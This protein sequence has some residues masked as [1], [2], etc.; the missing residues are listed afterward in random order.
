MLLTKKIADF[1][2]KFWGKYQWNNYKEGLDSSRAKIVALLSKNTHVIIDVGCGIG[3]LEHILTSVSP[4]NYVIGVDIS[5]RACKIAHELNR[6]TEFIVADISHLPLRDRL[7]DLIVLS[8]V[9][10]HIHRR[11][12]KD[13]IQ[14]LRRVVCPG[15]Y[16]FLTAP[17]GLHPTIILRKLFNW[18]SAEFFSFSDQIYDNPPSLHSL[19]K[20]LK[21]LE[22]KVLYL[23][24]SN[25][26]SLTRFK[27]KVPR[28]RFFA[29]QVLVIVQA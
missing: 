5:A 27:I 4:Q 17:N 18:I 1:Y 10:E 7:A 23:C 21:N 2:D 19:I 15:K 8:E 12:R 28:C 24:F 3:S 26:T 20:L 6:N 22:W 16:L 14:E 29:S 25:Y 9:I 13:V 11:N